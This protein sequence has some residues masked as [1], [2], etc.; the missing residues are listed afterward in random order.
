MSPT[1]LQGRSILVLEDEALVR[2]DVT[3]ILRGSGARVRSAQSVEDALLAIQTETL[4]AA[5]LDLKIHDGD[6]SEVVD[7][8][9]ERGVPMIFHT[10]YATAHVSSKWPGVAVLGKPVTPTQMVDAVA[11]LLAA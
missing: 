6:C 10:G 3:S 5:V 4:S 9:A 8:L 2:L 7:R 1:R 11:E